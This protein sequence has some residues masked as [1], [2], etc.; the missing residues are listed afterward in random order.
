MQTFQRQAILF[1][2][3]L[4][5]G[6]GSNSPGTMNVSTGTGG[7]GG[8]AAPGTGGTTAGNGGRD[9]GAGQGGAGGATTNTP[10]AG[11][12]ANDLGKACAS[13]S[14][15]GGGLTC[16]LPTD[17]AFG[18]GGAAHGYCTKPCGAADAGNACSPL[19]GVC[20]DLGTTDAPAPYCMQGCTFG[21]AA[22]RTTKCRGRDDV[23]CASLAS[24]GGGVTLYACL[25][26]CAVDSDCPS[27]RRCDE[28]TGVC[29]SGAAPSGTPL[30]SACAQTADGGA[31]VCSGFCLSSGSNGTVTARF[32]S[33]ACVL[34]A[35]SA[36]NLAFGT[37]A[38]AGASHGGCLLAITGADIGDIGFCSQECDTVADCLDKTDTTGMC[39]TTVA[40]GTSIAPHGFCTF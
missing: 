25:P 24:G 23:G 10:D 28:A 29:M 22:D 2:V 27:G 37:A 20:V 21:A 11:Q 40:A 6:C 12:A 4:T 1:F 35:A 19:G 5:A 15:C 16:V 8:A 26:M 36:C 3:A 38:L 39:N 31:D 18:G 17:T 7:H 32:C 30:G 14:D 33:R 13:A 34:G 9:G